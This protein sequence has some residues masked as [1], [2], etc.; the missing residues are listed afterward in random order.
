MRKFTLGITSPVLEATLV[1]VASLVI[2]SGL[3]WAYAGG[4]SLNQLATAPEPRS[5]KTNDQTT[6]RARGQYPPSIEQPV[7]RQEATETRNAAPMRSEERGTHPGALAGSLATNLVSIVG[8][9]NE[10][11]HPTDRRKPTSPS[12]RSKSVEEKR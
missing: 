4:T 8:Q 1:C 11:R 9:F 3:A 6:A 5:T 12:T 7:P 10:Q 2:V